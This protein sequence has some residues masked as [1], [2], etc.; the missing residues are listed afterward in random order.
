MDKAQRKSF[1]YYFIL[2]LINPFISTLYLLKNFRNVQSIWPFLLVSLF[3]GLS[4]VLDPTGAADSMRYADELEEIYVQQTS[5]SEYIVGGYLARDRDLDLYQP[6]VTWLV[7]R[8]TN[9]YKFLFVVFA[10]VFGYFWFKSLMLIRKELTSHLAFLSAIVFLVLA[11]TNPIWNINGV[12]MWTAMHVFF[13]G[14]LL[15][16]LQGKTKG[17]VFMAISPLIHF[18]LSIPLF[19]FIVYKFVPI[20]SIHLFFGVYV[21]AFFLGELDLALI[22]EQF[23]Q[24]PEFLQSKKSYLGET[25]VEKIQEDYGMYSWH[26][27]FASILIQYTAFFMILWMYLQRFRKSDFENSLFIRI[28]G[29]T[30]FFSAFALLVSKI[31]SGGRFM[32]LSN[33][34]VYVSFLLFLN[35]N[36]QSV[37]KLL[38][39]VLSLALIFILVFQMRKGLDY[40][41]ITY[42]VGNPL[43]NM[44]IS[45]EV[46]FIDYIKSIWW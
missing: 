40:I 14:F 42:F 28:F 44:W 1:R 11:L 33:S 5:F 41:G 38:Q 25:Y 45:D 10:V 43:V 13:Y 7:S 46:P 32:I 23:E 27:V 3:F 29:F 17:W 9:N 19:V 31:P 35:Q 21:L 37:F 4:F 34:L 36:Q 8:F 15:L 26:V 30:I 2:W 12:R 18:S 22:R 16:H 24:L 6:L 39:T 20:K